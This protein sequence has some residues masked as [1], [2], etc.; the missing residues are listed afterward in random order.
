MRKLFIAAVALAAVSTHAYA[1][2]CEDAI[3][4]VTTALETAKLSDD[5][6]AVV[7]DMLQSANEDLKSGEVEACMETMQDAQ[8]LL[9]Q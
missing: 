5:D 4:Q 1:D 6:K 2:E 7:E 3:K 9:G 8:S